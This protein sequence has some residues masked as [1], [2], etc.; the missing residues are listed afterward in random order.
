MARYVSTLTFDCTT[1]VILHLSANLPGA[2][3]PIP[4][5]SDAALIA[6]AGLL[7]LL[8]APMLR[9]RKIAPFITRR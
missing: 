4:T 3:E 9:K 7:A 1:G 5:L 6:M 8:G 2:P